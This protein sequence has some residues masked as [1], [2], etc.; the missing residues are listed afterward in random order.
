M[1]EGPRPKKK[2]APLS[3]KPTLSLKQIYQARKRAE[4]EP[5]VLF[6]KWNSAFHAGA[7]AKRMDWARVSTV[8]GDPIAEQ[9]F[10]E[11]YDGKTWEEAVKHLIGQ[12]KPKPVPA[13]K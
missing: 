2:E 4:I 7:K 1:E 10:F 6:Q 8:Y 11:G 9:F 3:E 12:A 13:S 5:R